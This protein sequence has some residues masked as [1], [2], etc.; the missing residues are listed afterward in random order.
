M[1]GE[2][3]PEAVVEGGGPLEA[4]TTSST[5]K[6]TNKASLPSLRGRERFMERFCQKEMSRPGPGSKEDQTLRNNIYIYINLTNNNCVKEKY[7]Y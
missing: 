2:G 7:A 4:V 6:D 1:G 3:E 5:T